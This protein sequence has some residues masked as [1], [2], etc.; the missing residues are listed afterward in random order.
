M[1]NLSLSGAH[2]ATVTGRP[3][4]KL[5]SPVYTSSSATSRKPL[6]ATVNRSLPG[7]SFHP[8]YRTIDSP[9]IIG[10]IRM[11]KR[12]SPFLLLEGSQ[13]PTLNIHIPPSGDLLFEQSGTL[14]LRDSF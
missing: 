14:Q 1:R 7:R 3:R 11:A 5:C 12:H 2:S 13:W 10:I 8:S 9:V 6:K 4:P